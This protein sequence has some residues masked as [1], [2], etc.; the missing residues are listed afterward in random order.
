MYYITLVAKFGNRCCMVWAHRQD[1]QLY[2]L[3]FQR[4]QK[5]VTCCFTTYFQTRFSILA[6]YNIFKYQNLSRH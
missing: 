4:R 2:S 6:Y 1:Q 5:K 3:S